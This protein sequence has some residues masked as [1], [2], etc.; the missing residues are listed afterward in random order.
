M[1]STTGMYLCR[2]FFFFFFSS[3]FFIWLE[4]TR[5]FSIFC[6]YK[7]FK[8]I[9]NLKKKLKKVNNLYL[10]WSSIIKIYISFLLIIQLYLKFFYF[11]FVVQILNTW[12]HTASQSR[13]RMWIKKRQCCI[14]FIWKFNCVF[15][16]PCLFDSIKKTQLRRKK[17]ASSYFTIN[18]SI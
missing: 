3:L 13:V 11:C 9:A 5:R 12:H 18:E 4:E 8:S 7:S 17:N 14:L 16:M 2:A 1:I 6:C 10:W 15:S